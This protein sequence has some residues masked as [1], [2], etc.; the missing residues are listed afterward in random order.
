M[1]ISCV[2]HV[3]GYVKFIFTGLIQKSASNFN[4][5]LDEQYN[6]V[7][8]VFGIKL[9]LIEDVMNSTIPTDFNFN[10]LAQ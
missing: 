2:P 1:H 5:E 10:L 8:I 4:T 6:F 3:N 9:A 7:L